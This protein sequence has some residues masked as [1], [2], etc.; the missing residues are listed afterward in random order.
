MG[1]LHQIMY[2]NV[3]NDSKRTPLHILYAQCIHG[4]C[5]IRELITSFNYYVL[6]NSYNVLQGYHNDMVSDIVQSS[7][8]KVLMPSQFDLD[9]FTLAAFVSLDHEETALTGI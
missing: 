6:A 7:N 3:H 9:V 8:G 1:V 2:L 5:K 4:K